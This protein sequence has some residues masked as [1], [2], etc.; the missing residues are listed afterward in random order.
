MSDPEYFT[1]AEFRGLPDMS[2]T[3]KY[4]DARVLAAAAYITA[5]VERVVGTSFIARTVT[6]EVRNGGS[7]GIPLKKLHVLSVTS[8]TENGVAVTDTLTAEYGVLR[9]YPTG[10]L[11]PREW[12]DG[13]GNIRVT[14]Q[15]G[16]SSTPPGD[17]K[18]AVMQGTRARLLDYDSTARLNDRRSS[19]SNDTG[20]TTTFVLAGVERPT[21]YPDVDAVI[22]G[23]RDLLAGPGVS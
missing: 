1:L 16:Y 12:Y 17:L 4:T 15:A 19:I 20:G 22:L 2:N 23:Y 3:T 10:S 5:I 7:C 6:S 18:E 11:I 13:I 21:G 14:Y 9:R 8:A